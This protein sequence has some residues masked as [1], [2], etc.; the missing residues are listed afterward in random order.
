MRLNHLAALSLGILLGCRAETFTSPGP[1]TI[2]VVSGPPAIVSLT[3]TLDSPIV[4]RVVDQDG[5]PLAGVPVTWSVLDGD[6]VILPVSGT[7]E[8]DGLARADWRFGVIPGHQEVIVEVAG[9][10][11]LR[12]TT[13]ARA[14]ELEQIV[15][16]YGRGCGL[17]SLGAAWCWGGDQPEENGGVSVVDR[18]RPIQ[19]PGGHQFVELD[20]G[21]SFTCGRTSS[22]EIWCWGGNWG[23]ALGDPDH[24]HSAMPV[25]IDGVPPATA[26]YAGAM[27][28]CA[29][30]PD[31]ATWCWGFVSDSSL[32]FASV[33]RAATQLA[34]SLQ[35]VELAPGSWHTCGRTAGG[36]V[37][38]WGVN[39][40]G[41]LGDSGASRNGPTT[42]VLGGLPFAEVQSGDNNTCARTSAGEVWCWGS[43]QVRGSVPTSPMRLEAPPASGI[44]VAFGFIATRHL[45]GRVRFQPDGFR[46]QEIP[47]GIASLGV[48][49]LTGR[50]DYCMLTAGG[51]AYCSGGA[52]D[53]GS[54]SAV[55]PYGCAPFG[56]VPLPTGGKIVEWWNRWEDGTSPPG[57]PRPR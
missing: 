33:G 13:E 10:D 41:Q 24:P 48:G 3:T 9:L 7:T 11:P 21:D 25:R 14:F 15:A 5:T 40:S 32:S 4:I 57:A 2:E 51:A 28:G 22:G 34:T 19:V 30:T 45:A 17:D 42:P 23:G 43:D 39:S 38:C 12:V 20:A 54:C 52:I 46:A 6:G 29:L 37:Y 1:T 50:G 49:P 16:G 18:Y 8:A 36:A 27:H 55:A 44:A 35:F 26:V 47:L 56:P 31:A 53:G